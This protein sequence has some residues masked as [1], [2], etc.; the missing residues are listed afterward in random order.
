MEKDGQEGFKNFIEPLNDMADSQDIGKSVEIKADGNWFT[1]N[2]KAVQ[3]KENRLVISA[4]RKLDGLTDCSHDP[5][6]MEYMVAFNGTRAAYLRGFYEARHH[7]Y[8]KPHIHWDIRSYTNS[9]VNP[10]VRIYV[11][12][13]RAS[14]E[15][16]KL[17][18]AMEGVHGTSNIINKY[19]NDNLLR[20]Q[21][22]IKSKKTPQQIEKEWSKGLME[23]LGYHHVEAADTGYPKG[24]WREVEVHWCK[25]KQDL[26]I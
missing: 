9:P 2:F 13:F 1:L 24:H 7:F 26:K 19:I 22:G 3:V 17:I 10:T 5:S 8:R 14:D 20:F 6:A 4:T 11:N 23:S 12:G 16:R 21:L 15:I 18:L 25:K